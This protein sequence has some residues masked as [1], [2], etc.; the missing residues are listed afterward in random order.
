MS[1][2]EESAPEKTYICERVYTDISISGENAPENIEL[3]YLVIGTDASFTEFTARNQVMATAPMIY[4][5]CTRKSIDLDKSEGAAIYFRVTYEKTGSEPTTET[6]TEPEVSFDLS[7]S[8]VTMKR[9][10]AQSS[11]GSE[12]PDA[13]LTIGWNGKSGDQCEVAGVEVSTCMIRKSYT[14]QM[15]Y[16]EL[17][18]EW[19][20]KIAKLFGCVNDTAW[21]GYS[22][23]E[24]L[25]L[26]CS[27]SGV[28][29]KKTVFN[30]TFNFGISF[31]ETGIDVG[32]DS[33]GKTINVN[34]TGWQYVW[35]IVKSQYSDIDSP[36]AIKIMGV[37]VSTV[38]KT[39]SFGQ[40]GI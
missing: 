17:T 3:V 6:T 26:G 2:T 25:F 12:A 27:F 16:S 32:K 11:Y 8:P 30:V 29:S 20:K 18:T 38:Y 10:Y 40:L 13:G 7:S 9:A 36:P 21:K 39:G 35:D 5:G 33:K 15:K 31:N 37:Y 24:V 19:E 28:D 34:K 23:G 22:A 14:V 1:T 4:E